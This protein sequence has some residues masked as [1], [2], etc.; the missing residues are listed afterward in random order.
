MSTEADRVVLPGAVTASDRD[1]AARYLVER[2]QVSERLRG[3]VEAETAASQVL[4]TTRSALVTAQTAAT[5]AEKLMAATPEMIP[6]FVFP[7][8]GPTSFISSYGFC[9]DGCSRSHQG[10]DLFDLGFERFE[11]DIHGAHYRG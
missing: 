4:E 7:V 1:L 11:F 2:K 5:D 10:N 9:R 3:S 8:A 6:G